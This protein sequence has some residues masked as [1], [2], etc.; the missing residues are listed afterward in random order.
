MGPGHCGTHREPGQVPKPL[1]GSAT[2]SHYR[3]NTKPHSHFVSLVRFSDLLETWAHLEDIRISGGG[4]QRFSFSFQTSRSQ[5]AEIFPT[6]LLPYIVKV[7]YNDFC[8]ASFACNMQVSSLGRFN[9]EKLQPCTFFP[10]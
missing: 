10:P 5:R 8:K 2:G 4:T 7:L 9:T 6:S 3:V 1:S